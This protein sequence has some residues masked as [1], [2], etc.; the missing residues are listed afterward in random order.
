MGWAMPQACSIKTYI[1]DDQPS[2]RTE[3][4]AVFGALT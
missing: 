3:S 1:V 2:L 4:E